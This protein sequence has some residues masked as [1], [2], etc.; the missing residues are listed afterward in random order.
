MH[1][2][3]LSKK[4]FSLSLDFHGISLNLQEDMSPI[5]IV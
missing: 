1:I 5:R 2:F 4:N 3:S